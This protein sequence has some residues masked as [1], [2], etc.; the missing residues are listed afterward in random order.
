MT[1]A[2]FIR[3]ELDPFKI[4][5]FRQYADR[6]ARIIPRCGGHLI[7][8]F[9][10][11]EGTNYEGW[12]LIAFASLA[13]YEPYR[14]RLK[15]DAEGRENF[16]FAQQERFI[17]REQRSFTEVVDSTWLKAPLAEAMETVETVQTVEAV[18]ATP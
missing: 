6:W 15:R 3:Y 11:H 2:C 10:P 18:G 17:L 14:Q 7:G 9:A 1:I 4:D 13:D 16:A 8:Y 12:G 5:L